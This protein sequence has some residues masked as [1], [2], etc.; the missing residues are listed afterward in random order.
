MKFELIES[1]KNDIKILKKYKRCTIMD[2]APK[3]L[4][5][6]ELQRIDNYINDNVS[7][8]L[9]EYKLI[10][11]NNNIAGCVL[12]KKHDDGILLDELYLEEEYR[13]KGIGSKILNKLI[14]SNNII[15]LYVFKKN[16]DAIKLYKKYGFFI[17]KEFD[18]RYYMK[19][20]K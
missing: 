10:I 18:F 1:N 12:V 8:D 9:K 13:N 6:S 7:K 17:E 16:L 14:E 15:Y 11:V 5:E 20:S 3:D 4:P 2:Y 19:Y